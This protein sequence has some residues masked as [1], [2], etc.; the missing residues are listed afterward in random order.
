MAVLDLRQE[1]RAARPRLDHE[2]GELREAVVATWRGRMVNEHGS[3]RVFAALAAQLADAGFDSAWSDACRG[4]AEEER[5]H[6]VLC[7]AVVEALGG[8]AMAPA[9]EEHDLP[10][11]D[12][13]V[14]KHAAAMR[15]VLSVACL[16]ETVAVALIGAERLEMPDGALRD[17]LTTIYADEVGHARF[18]WR[19]AA[20]SAP[21]WDDA[22]RAD[23]SKYLRVAFRHLEMHELAHLPVSSRPPAEGARFGLCSGQDARAL[24]YDTVES[25]I[26]PGL[27]AFG[28]AARES[29]AARHVPMQAQAQ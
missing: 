7:G 24:F 3:S 27:E 5:R 4:F 1:A 10:L 12:D 23:L 17:L 20:S 16:S 13:A 18:G 6:G 14:S 22:T 26:V 11:H 2:P 8:E 28:L 15:N 25:V 21:S 29:W 9:R 19:L